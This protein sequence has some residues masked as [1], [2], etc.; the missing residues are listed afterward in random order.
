MGH[1]ITVLNKSPLYSKT[2]E[3]KYMM[4]RTNDP[5][6]RREK[7]IQ[8]MSET[9]YQKWQ[10]FTDLLTGTFP[11]QSEG[12]SAIVA[13]GGCTLTFKAYNQRFDLNCRGRLLGK[14]EPLYQATWWHNVLFNPDLNPDTVIL[15]FAPSWEASS[16]DPQL[17]GS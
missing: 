12:A 4:M 11:P 5:A 3:L 6:E 15:C 10:E 2:P 7:A 17:A 9:Y 1:I 13:A 16:S 14:A 8:L